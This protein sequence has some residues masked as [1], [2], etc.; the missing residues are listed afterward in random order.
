MTFAAEDKHEFEKDSD[1]ESVES[2]STLEDK[3]GSIGTF[4]FYI[5][6][7]IPV[8]GI[9]FCFIHTEQERFWTWTGDTANEAQSF[10]SK[11]VVSVISTVI[12]GCV[13]ATLMK[14]VSSISYTV[15]RHQGAHFSHLVTV[16]GG[17]SPG[18][19]PMLITG[20]R[21]I[22]IIL[23]ILILII[24]AV[25]KQLTFIS[26]GVSYVSSGNETASFS[27][28][29][30]S[31]C[32]ATNITDAVNGFF[33]ILALD[34]LNSLR[35]PNTS[36]TNEYYD[37]SIPTGLIGES[38]FQR[39]LP[40]SNVSCKIVKTQPNFEHSKP[41]ISMVPSSENSLLALSWAGHISI[42]YQD[43][44]TYIMPENYIN[45]TIDLGHATAVTSCN[46][47]LCHT[48]R[49]SKITPYDKEQ[50]NG[51]FV[52]LLYKMFNITQPYGTAVRNSLVVWVAG[53]D[54]TKIYGTDEYIPGENKQVITSRL[55]ILGT[56]AARILCDYN[57]KDRSKEKLVL[58]TSFQTYF[59]PFQY[60][61]YHILW[62]WPFW[63]LAGFILVLWLASMVSLRITPES[64]VISVEWLLSQ[65]I[66]KERL[67]Y[68]S[69]SQLVKAHKGSIFQVV[70]SKEDAEVGSIVISKI[71]PY[72]SKS[73]VRIL[74]K[75][76]YQ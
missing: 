35:N 73:H 25:I 28:R 29:N 26:M 46:R 17:H 15:I 13:L 69:G 8:I 75:K 54:W 40:Y 62:K 9:I 66:M 51:G 76:R 19:L 65:Y 74:H 61:T 59:Q 18:H 52:D 20:K 60:Y 70:D 63:M 6:S 22:S 33:P 49:T 4:D 27:V 64:R 47:T 71:D 38:K 7:I 12:S 1:L 48:K 37:R 2:S 72:G 5:W 53:G 58:L 42:P 39:E 56:V 10:E 24:G 32:E 57:N 21:W 36:Y 68:V 50:V 44:Y 67:G 43:N 45:C 11:V 3:P 34:A 41:M 55:E 14:T 31:T 23:I 16:I 30:Y